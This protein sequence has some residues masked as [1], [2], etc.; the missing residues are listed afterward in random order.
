MIIKINKQDTHTVSKKAS[1]MDGV[2]CLELARTVAGR[3]EG[4]IY[5]CPLGVAKVC[6]EK[7]CTSRVDKGRSTPA[8]VDS[9]KVGHGAVRVF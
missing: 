8:E 9:W 5:G 1:S 7:I 3:A 6:Q 4:N 2:G